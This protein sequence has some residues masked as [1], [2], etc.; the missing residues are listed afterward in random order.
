MIY[1]AIATTFRIVN[2]RHYDRLVDLIEKTKGDLVIGG[3][4]NE[5]ER[6]ID[7]HVYTNVRGDDVLMQDELFG[8]ILPI[9]RADS[10]DEAIAFINSKEKP[11]SLYIFS[12]SKATREAILN[13]VPNIKYNSAP[14]I[15]VYLAVKILTV[16]EFWTAI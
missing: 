15:D 8:P 6:F 11:L 10:V 16:A 4:R 9:I 2:T 3:S 5:K 7:L 1:F 12:E 14:F 13:Q